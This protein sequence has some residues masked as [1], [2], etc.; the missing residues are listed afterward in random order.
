MVWW[1][2]LS[3]WHR[4]IG[5]WD[6][7]ACVGCQVHGQPRPWH[8]LPPRPLCWCTQR[9]E[10]HDQRRGHHRRCGCLLLACNG[11]DDHRATS[12]SRADVGHGPAH[13][14]NPSAPGTLLAPAPDLL[15]ARPRTRHLDRRQARGRGR[16]D[17][18]NA[19]CKWQRKPSSLA[20]A[21]RP[22]LSLLC[23]SDTASACSCRRMASTRECCTRTLPILCN[24]A[25]AFF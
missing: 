14:P 6:G 10:R 5:A 4:L 3:W 12:A 25:A 17:R 21:S 1:L 16:D 2:R 24:P 15:R 9:H 13:R 22:P 19:E 18:L 11:G 23:L 8:P 20:G 7:G